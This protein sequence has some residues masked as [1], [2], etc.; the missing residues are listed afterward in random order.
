[1]R[2]SRIGTI[3]IVSLAAL[4]VFGGLSADASGR[5]LRRDEVLRMINRTRVAHGLHRVDAQ[6]FLTRSARRHSRDMA[7]KG[8]IFHTVSLATDLRRVSWTIAGENVGAGHDTRTLFRAFMRSAPHR[9]NILRSSFHHVG[10]GLVR[11][12]GFLWATLIFYG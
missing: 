4:V 8:Y 12:D 6:R 9:H 3:V 1:M 11:A 5:T 10:V 2:R 7:K